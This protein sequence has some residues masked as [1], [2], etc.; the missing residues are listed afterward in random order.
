M[1]R[2]MEINHHRTYRGKAAALLF[3]TAALLTGCASERTEDELSYRKIGIESMQSGDYE[4][5]LA[6][7]DGALACCTGK[8][9]D[10]EID[11]CYYKAAAQ[12]A[13][14]D[15]E[16]A[17]ETYNAMIDYDGKNANAYYLRGCLK[18]GT[19]DTDGAKQDFADAVKYNH[20]DYELYINIYK[21][22][23]AYDLSEEGEAYLNDAFSIK[24]NDAESLAYR[25]EIYYLLGQYDNAIKEL[26]SAIDAGS[27]A[28][29]LTL[30]RVYEA[31]QDTANAQ[32]YYQA[33]VDAGVADSE[34]MNALAQIEM[35]KLN[36][37]GALSYIEQG[38]SMESVPNRRALLQNQIICMEY[39]GDFAGAYEVMTAYTAAYPDD[40][41]ALREYTFLK[42]RVDTPAGT[43]VQGEVVVTEDI[44]TAEADSGTDGTD[45][46]TDGT[47]GADG[48]DSGADA[49]T[50]G[51]GDSGQ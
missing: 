21:N 3:V 4:G 5:A 48:T 38:L 14:Q 49:G 15:T 17:L 7:F 43:E 24:G 32:T 37:S 29:N 40:A 33:Y 41:E 2:R 36:Y 46:G 34:A 26:T 28:A 20:S 13:A 25:G 23:A 30:A 11:I 10:L 16:G 42:S 35:G 18:L 1:R 22:L 19:G 50:D 31:Q 44:G 47:D 8:I 39:T 51:S 9:T 45:S 12:Y 6:A 27:A